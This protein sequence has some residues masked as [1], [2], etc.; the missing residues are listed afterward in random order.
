MPPGQ[1][2]LYYQISMFKQNNYQ[3][4]I[5]ITDLND[6]QKTKAD[7]LIKLSKD[8]LH[9]LNIVNDPEIKPKFKIIERLANNPLKVLKQYL[10][11]N[12]KNAYNLVILSKEHP[13]RMLKALNIGKGENV[14]K[15]EAA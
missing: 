12:L 14:R 9:I 6:E 11:D 1:K 13:S 2:K 10:P 8:P 4:L 3:A 7:L 5:E 15:I